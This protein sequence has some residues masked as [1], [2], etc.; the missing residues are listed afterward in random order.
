VTTIESVLL[1][2]WLAGRGVGAV[3]LRPDRIVLAAAPSAGPGEPVGAEIPAALR[4]G[5]DRRPR[6]TEW[7]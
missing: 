5:P 2:D 1:S 3:L 6:H 7:R 4:A